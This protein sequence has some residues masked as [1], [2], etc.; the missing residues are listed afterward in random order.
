MPIMFNTLLH[1]EGLAL[2]NVRLLRH[3]DNRVDKGRTP[4]RLW[5][6]N[7]A[8]FELYQSHQSKER[9]KFDA[10]YWASFVGTPDNKTLF[11]GL[12]SAKYKGRLERDTPMPNGGV[13]I[14]GSCDVYDLIL[15]KRLGDLIGKLFIEWGTGYRAWV[16]RADRQNKAITE[17][18]DNLQEPIFP[19]FL[20]FIKPLSEIDGLPHGWIAILRNSKGIY[21]LTCPKTKEQYVGKA[22]SAN[23]FWQRWQEYTKTGHGGNVALKSREASDYQ[24]SILEVA[25]TAATAEEIQAMEDRWK[26]KL[27]SREMGLNRN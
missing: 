26:S 27:Q 8:D 22:D 16:Q 9:I 15:D 10:P 14:A 21:L 25:G 5:Y 24:V 17:L 3:Q 6:N 11:V 2:E 18:R 19:G 23:G 4:Y 1:T 7:P 20:N 12:Y 13:E